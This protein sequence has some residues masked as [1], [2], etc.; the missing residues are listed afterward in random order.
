MI[1]DPQL[2]LVNV[3]LTALGPPATCRSL[4]S[5]SWTLVCVGEAQLVGLHLP[6]GLLADPE[7]LHDRVVAAARVLDHRGDLGRGDPGAP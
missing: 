5:A 2:A 4:A 7:L 6:L 3:M 1:C